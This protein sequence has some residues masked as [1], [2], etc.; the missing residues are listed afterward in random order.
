[1]AVHAEPADN[2]R[3]DISGFFWS[4]GTGWKLLSKIDTNR[5]GKPWYLGGLYSFV[6]QWTK[7]NTLENRDSMYGPSWISAEGAE[8][9][10]VMQARYSFGTPENHEHVNGYFN[11]A[12]NNVGIATGGD[13]EPIASKNQ[14]FNYNV[15]DEQPAALVDFNARVACITA[16]TDATEMDACLVEVVSVDCVES[17]AERGS[18]TAVGQE[19]YTLTTAA[20]GTGAPCTGESTL[21]VTGDF[22]NP[23]DDEEEGGEVEGDEDPIIKEEDSA[24][25]KVQVMSASSALSALLVYLNF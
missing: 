15:E 25:T 16:A 23:E 8:W 1:M 18:C 21:C 3:V 22:I 2:N 20:E 6:E 12:G 13:V 19:L 5:S 10:Q 9:H 14:M 24:A 17:T 7:G 11:A 4:S